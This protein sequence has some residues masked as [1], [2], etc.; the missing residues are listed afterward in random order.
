MSADVSAIVDEVIAASPPI[1]GSIDELTPTQR[2]ELDH[3]VRRS[4]IT[5]EAAL[6]VIRGRRQAQHAELEKRRALDGLAA[7]IRAH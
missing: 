2:K 6:S 4:A 5:P 1:P 3:L 7:S